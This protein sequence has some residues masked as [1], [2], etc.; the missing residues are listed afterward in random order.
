MAWTAPDEPTTEIGF[1]AQLSEE[2]TR[3][4]GTIRRRIGAPTMNQTLA[5]IIRELFNSREAKQDLKENRP[6]ASFGQ[7]EFRRDIMEEDC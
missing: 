4:L 3:Q 2:T 6:L 5:V 7:G 1:T